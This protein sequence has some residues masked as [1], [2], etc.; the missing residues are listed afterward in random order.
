MV[1]RVGLLGP[2]YECLGFG[3][4]GGRVKGVGIGGWKGGLVV[5]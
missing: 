5:Y 2:P 1:K 3:V 4:V